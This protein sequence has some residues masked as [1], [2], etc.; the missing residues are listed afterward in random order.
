MYPNDT[1][2]KFVMV[3]I[4]I[5]AAAIALIVL[6]SITMIFIR[7]LRKIVLFV[8]G[9]FL[10]ALALIWF[11][12]FRTVKYEKTYLNDTASWKDLSIR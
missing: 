2:A 5:L 10:L 12:F 8:F 3:I 1:L 4:K 9:S 6:A 11:F 7:R